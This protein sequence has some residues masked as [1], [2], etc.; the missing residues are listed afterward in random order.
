MGD[1]AMTEDPKIEGEGSHTAA[2]TYNEQQR[3]FVESEDIDAKA[4]EAKEAV[5]G[6]ESETLADAEEEGRSRAKSDDV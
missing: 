1:K 5:D 6:A 3:E 2:R 4:E